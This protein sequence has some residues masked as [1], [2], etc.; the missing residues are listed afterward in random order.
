MLV[1][2]LCEQ[3]IRVGTVKHTHTGYQLDHPGKDSHRHGEA[4]ALATVLIGPEE[5]AVIHRQ[6]QR[7]SLRDACSMI[8]ARV[9]VVLAEGFRSESGPSI[10]LDQTQSDRLSVEADAAV[11]GVLPDEL[12][13]DELQQLVDLCNPNFPR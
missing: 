6:L 2:R 8:A 12:A 4:G 11:V 10:T 5:S 7:P 9:D 3:G 1:T 13:A